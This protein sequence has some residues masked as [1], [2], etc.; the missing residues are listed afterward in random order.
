MISFLLVSFLYTRV[1][2]ALLHVYNYVLYALARAPLANVFTAGSACLRLL[3]D[4]E[5]L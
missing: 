5:N 4:F 1:L 2:C 3:S